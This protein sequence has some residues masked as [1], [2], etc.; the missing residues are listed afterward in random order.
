MLLPKHPTLYRTGRSTAP[1]ARFCTRFL[2]RS[3][4]LAAHCRLSLFRVA[5][6]A[7]PRAGAR[8]PPA[9][10]PS[11]RPKALSWL[12]ARVCRVLPPSPLDTMMM[13]G[14]KM[15]AAF[16]A[17]D[18]ELVDDGAATDVVEETLFYPDDKNTEDMGMY[19][20][21]LPANVYT[22]TIVCY[23]NRPTASAGLSKVLVYLALPVSMTLVVQTSFSY[24]LVEGVRHGRLAS[25]CAG[26]SFYLRCLALSAFVC[27]S[28]RDLLHIVETHQW[29]QMFR[30]VASHERL[31]L[32]QTLTPLRYSEDAGEEVELK[33][34]TRQPISGITC[35]A[36]ASFYALALAPWLFVWLLVVIA[37]SGA[38]LRSSDN[39]NLVL[40]SV[41]AAFV[42]E[43]DDM[44]YPLLVPHSVRI[45]TDLDSFPIHANE[46]TWLWWTTELFA[47][48]VTAAVFALDVPLYGVWCGM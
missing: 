43:L 29:L 3:R 36:R 16:H 46:T 30:A 28:L 20:R 23:L 21:K 4:S 31:R 47:F 35:C 32:Q 41:A 26:T 11:G 27:L 38:L 2:P 18:S 5:S 9:G 15:A 24:F 12:F 39:V 19:R 42:L 44:L 10:Y 13:M 45:M 48:I 14:Q 34:I 22:A 8:S 1:N 25:S 6:P 33:L 17:A 40:N 7:S 37:G